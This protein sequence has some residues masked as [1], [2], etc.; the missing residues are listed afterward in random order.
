MVKRISKLPSTNLM[1]LKL[2]SLENVIGVLLAILI[3]FDLKVEE[4][5]CKLINTNVGKIMS[6]I[7]AILLFAMV[8]PIVGILFVIYVYQCFN[9]VISHNEV[10][11]ASMLE[12]LNPPLVTQVEEE[13]ILNK[14]PIKNQNL[15]SNVEFSSYSTNVGSPL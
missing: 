2:L 3:I 15:N 7:V 6:V 11:K 1:S 5:I 9:S 12:K 4:P 8:H 13:V 14:A 10:N